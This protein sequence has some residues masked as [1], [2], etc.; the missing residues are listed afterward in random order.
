MSEWV[1]VTKDEEEKKEKV[2]MWDPSAAGE[3]IQGIYIDKEEDV[4]QYKS[5]MYTLKTSDG[6]VKFWGSTVLDNLMEKVP[7]SSEVRVTFQGTQPSKSGRNPWKDYRVEY[8]K[9]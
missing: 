4:G 6:E 5:N 3:S 9:V 8:R 7:F 1:E 2:N